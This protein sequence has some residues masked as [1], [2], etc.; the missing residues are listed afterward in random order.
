IGSYV[1]F[2]YAVC[3]CLGLE[4]EVLLVAWAD[5]SLGVVYG[6]YEAVLSNVTV[7]AGRK[8]KFE[9]ATSR[10][11]LQGFSAKADADRSSITVAKAVAGLRI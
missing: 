5:G 11:D 3:E 2:A 9:F 8:A 6:M 4:V 10:Y 1:D 7:T